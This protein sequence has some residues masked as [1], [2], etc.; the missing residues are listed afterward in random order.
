AG[1]RTMLCV[2]YVW[3]RNDDPDMK[4]RRFVGP[5]GVADKHAVCPLEPLPWRQDLIEPALYALAEA[6]RLGVPDLFFGVW[7]DTEVLAEMGAAL[8]ERNANCLCDGCWSAFCAAHPGLKPAEPPATRGKALLLAGKTGAYK[9]WQ[10]QAVIDMIRRELQPVRQKAPALVFGF[11]TYHGGES[12]FTEAVLAAISTPRAPA[13]PMDDRTYW[14]GW[15]GKP[16]HVDKIRQSTIRLLGHEPLFA[17][18]IAYC[19][20]ERND[21]GSSRYPSYTP[22]RAGREAYLLLKSSL[23]AVM[24]GGSRD[25]KKDLLVDQTPH[26]TEGFAKAIKQLE[27]EGA[28]DQAAPKPP[29]GEERQ[30]LQKALAQLQR[31]ATGAWGSVC[32]QPRAHVD[33]P[34]SGVFNGPALTV[35]KNLA[36]S[37]IYNTSAADYVFDLQLNAQPKQAALEITAKPVPGQQQRTN[38]LVRIN[39]AKVD[40]LRHP[41]GPDGVARLTLPVEMIKGKIIVTLGYFLGDSI[42]DTAFDNSL[43]IKRIVLRLE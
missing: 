43:T 40:Y 38:L 1:A 13:I 7:F 6:S 3:T 21:D 12:W 18:S 30:R 8:G 36:K 35:T 5:T 4:L 16:T 14:T 9:A 24:W 34:A 2:G 20:P 17:P 37:L 32:G 15:S 23:A 31:E 25:P 42:T 22:D 27:T 11:Y 39:G 26:Y 28:I 29:Q 41:F 10:K 33:E 19:S